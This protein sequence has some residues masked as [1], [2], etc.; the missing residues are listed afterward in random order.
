[1]TSPNIDA[2]RRLDRLLKLQFLWSGLFLAGWLMIV[3]SDGFLNDGKPHTRTDDRQA[4][5]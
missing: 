1:M 2:A 3:L 5:Y 4:V